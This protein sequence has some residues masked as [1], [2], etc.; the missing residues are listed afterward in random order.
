MRPEYVDSSMDL[1]KA[2]KYAAIGVAAFVA[3]WIVLAIVSFL[4]DLALGLLALLFGLVVTAIA[5]L[6]LLGLGYAVVKGLLWLTSDDERSTTPPG[7]TTSRGETT[8]SRQT[9]TSADDRVDQLSERYVQGDLSE[10]EFERHLESQ[11]EDSEPGERDRE[12][13]RS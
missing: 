8:T 12:F 13:E 9:T 1:R 6:V 5:L 7:R 11:L 3:L 10:E 2:A 4:V